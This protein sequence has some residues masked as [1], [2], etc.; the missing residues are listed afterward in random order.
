MATNTIRRIAAVFVLL[1]VAACQGPIT[2]ETRIDTVAAKIEARKQKDIVVGEWARQ[3]VRLASIGGRILRDGARFCDKKAFSYGFFA[4]DETFFGEKWKK[5][6]ARSDGVSDLISVGGIIPGSQAEKAGLHVGDILVAVGGKSLPVGEKAHEKYNE[7]TTKAGENGAAVAFRVRRDGTELTFDL[8]PETVCNYTFALESEDVLNAYAD[9]KQIHVTS[10]IMNFIRTDQELA[11][12]LSHELAH[13]VMGH[14][15]T[16][17]TNT[18]LGGAGGFLIDA[19]AAL[20]G[21]NTG[22]EFTHLGARQGRAAYSV[23]FEQ[24]ADYVALY[25]MNEAGFNIDG[26]ANFWRR[27]AASSPLGIDRAS[28]HP[29]TSARFLGIEAT[30]KEIRDK[31]ARGLPMEPDLKKK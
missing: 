18:L 26:A 27:M 3:Y 25:I 31:Q 2:R 6:F 5:A 28:T 4:W 9:G 12:V 23:A 7:Y 13:N 19:V 16:A 14:V 20:S 17:K 24:E 15:Q 30:I 29:S 8:P 22:G 21:Y 10:R 11:L 1:T